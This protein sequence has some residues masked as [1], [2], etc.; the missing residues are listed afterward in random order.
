MDFMVIF[1]SIFALFTFGSICGWVLEVFFRRIFT[2]KKWINPGFMVGPYLPLYGFGTVALYGLSNINMEWFGLSSDNPWKW[3]I[4]VLLIGISM[5]LIEYI[6]GLIFIKGM[7]IKLW[8]Y[9]NRWGNI[10]GIICPLFSLLWLVVGVIYYFL[11][12]KYLVD[13]VYWLA[14]EEHQIFYF[15]VGAVAGMMLVDLCYSIHLATLIRKSA[16]NNKVTVSIEKF[17]ESLAEHQKEVKQK[18]QKKIKKP[19]FLF[20]LR[21]DK[22]MDENIDEYK[23]SSFYSDKEK[24]KDEKIY[25]NKK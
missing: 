20:A 13:G 17:K 9:S 4:I 23:N 5:T 2:S 7:K 19:N 18:V 1:A 11:I 8:D 16:M 12:N 10:Q 21:S 25:K 22:S 6:A 15:F 14:Q 24:K 3:V